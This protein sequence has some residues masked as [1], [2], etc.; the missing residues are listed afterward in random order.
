MRAPCSRRAQFRATGSASSRA[1]PDSVDPHDATGMAA[2]LGLSGPHRPRARRRRPLPAGER[3]RRAFR[4][5]ASARQSGVHRRRGTRRRGARGADFLAA[6]VRS[7]TSSE[8]F[9]AQIEGSPK[10]PGTREQAIRARRERR[11]GALVL[12]SPR[13]AIRIP[14]HAMRR[15]PDCGR[16]ESRRCRGPGSCA[17]G[18]RA[19]VDAPVRGARAR[20]LAGPERCGALPRRSRNGR[21]RGSSA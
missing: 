17:N 21:R 14:G 11:L 13:S 4:R 9:A 15:S 6:P 16:W 12:E 18:R 20:A 19:C 7:P 5:A 2:G 3:P 8:H 10:S 1:A